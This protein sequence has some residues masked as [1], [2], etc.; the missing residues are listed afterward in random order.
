MRTEKDP[1]KKSEKDRERKDERERKERDREDKDV[2]R[3]KQKE[4]EQRL[5][6][7]R[8]SARRADELI[9]KQSQVGEGGENFASPPGVLNLAEDKLV[10]K[11]KQRQCMP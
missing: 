4:L 9:R 6:H 7:K 8:K 3:E 1:R 10:S 11:S 5:P 2:E